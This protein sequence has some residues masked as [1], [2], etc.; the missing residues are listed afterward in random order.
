MKTLRMIVFLWIIIVGS[1][2]LTTR[3]L[4]TALLQMLI[5][6]ALLSLTAL[7]KIGRASCRERVCL[8]V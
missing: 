2:W 1:S 4:H 5:S 8:Y 7:I 3:S 6:A